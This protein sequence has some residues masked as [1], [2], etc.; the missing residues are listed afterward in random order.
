MPFTPQKQSKVNHRLPETAPASQAPQDQSLAT[1]PSKSKNDPNSLGFPDIELKPT[2]FAGG[3]EGGGDFPG[4][5][6]D[7][8][9]FLNGTTKAPGEE[10][11]ADKPGKQPITAKLCA[12][13]LKYANGPEAYAMPGLDNVWT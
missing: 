8:D 9:P 7:K 5:L 10:G 6:P 13:L 11:G 2:T 12:A 4:K 1:A 3:E